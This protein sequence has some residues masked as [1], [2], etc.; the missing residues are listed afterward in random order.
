EKYFKMKGKECKIG[1]F[2]SSIKIPS[3]DDINFFDILFYETEWY[4]K[5]SNLNRHSNIYHA[6]GI[7]TTI[8]KYIEMEKKYD[9]IFVGN[10][11]KYKRPL[12][13][14]NKKGTRLVVG[15][16]EDK[17]IVNELKKNDVEVLDFIEYEKL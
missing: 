1:I 14:I 6:F 10:I 7:D 11:V 9:Y 5:Y 13:I 3:D 8:M 2:I 4:K 12:N 17:N 15:F 16:M